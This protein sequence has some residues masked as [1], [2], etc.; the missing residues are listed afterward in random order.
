MVLFRGHGICSSLYNYANLTTYDEEVDS[1]GYRQGPP[2]SLSPTAR[3]TTC[4]P[5]YLVNASTPCGGAAPHRAPPALRSLDLRSPP[6]LP[7]PPPEAPPG[8]AR[9]T[10]RQRGS[11]WLRLGVAAAAPA[12]AAPAAVI[13]GDGGLRRDGG[14]AVGSG[15]GAGSI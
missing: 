2:V 13:C 12:S 6:P 14:K 7:P 10:W 1:N 4:V 15:G 11:C 8:K 5:V 9:A 3:R